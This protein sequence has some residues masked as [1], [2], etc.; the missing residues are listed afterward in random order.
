LPERLALLGVDHNKKT[1]E[2]WKAALK[3]FLAQVLAK[4]NE[5]VDEACGS[6]SPAAWTFSAAISRST[7]L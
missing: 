5:E 6:R 2:E 3:D 7:D 4:N 1:S